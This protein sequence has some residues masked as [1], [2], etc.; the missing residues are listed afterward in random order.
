MTR[1]HTSAL[2]LLF[3]IA[4]AYAQDQA[5][6]PSVLS[7]QPMTE[8][9]PTTQAP[10]TGAPAVDAPRTDAS[11]PQTPAASAPAP[12]ASSRPT[13]KL[14]EPKA[15]TGKA[16]KTEARQKKVREAAVSLDPEPSF[17]PGTAAAT[18]AAAEK[19][20]ALAA[21]GGWP[22]IDGDVRPE[23]T[24]AP[25]LALRQRLAL[26][27][28]LE[29][30][31]T[32]SDVFDDDLTLAVKS[33]QLRVGLKPTGIVAGATLTAINVPA[34]ARARQLAASAAR[35]EMSKFGFEDRHVVVNIPS[36]AVEAVENGQVV[37]RYTAIVGDVAHQSPQVSARIQEV[38]L[39]PTWTIPTSIIK[40]EIIPK[41]QK[42]PNY[43]TRAKIRILDGRGNEIDPR[44]IDWKTQKA[45][46]YTLR[47]DAGQSNSLGFIRIN[48]PNK[49]AVYL[50]DTPARGKFDED[51]RF[52]SHGCVRVEGVYELAEWLL[53]GAKAPDGAWDEK[54]MRAKVKT[55]ERTDIKPVKQVPVIWVYLT[56]WASDEGTVH[57]RDDVYGLDNVS[58][59][60][61]EQARAEPT[62][63]T[64]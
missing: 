11:G 3:A 21:A 19:Y 6:P 35:I 37:R 49:E 13:V 26:E 46:G 58:P 59:A 60:T 40:N 22:S 64:Q 28:D 8:Q 16:A 32:D 15:Q 24:G 57:F 43:L 52:L 39:N 7:P 5:L 23:T 2:A 45:A 54:A 44:R 20:E 53:K 55:K 42:N 30:E 48:M 31:S 9:T 27:G 47:Q 1:L 18:K 56:G 25:V 51:Y 33:F 14:D 62:R 63:A 29:R 10:G 36:A 50:H 17:Q 61:D 4:P 12:D 41:M 38:N 34:A